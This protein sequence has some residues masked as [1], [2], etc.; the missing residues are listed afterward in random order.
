[1]LKDILSALA[2]ESMQVKYLLNQVKVAHVIDGRI[3][4]IYEALKHDDEV[5]NSI[6]RNLDGIKEITE[7]KINRITGSVT[8]N[9]EPDSIVPNSFL[10]Q[11]IAGARAKYA[12][13]A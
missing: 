2:P 11:L 3:R 9:Y 7:W 6:C 4:V 12:K 10:G 8:I 1:M 5:Y 13:E